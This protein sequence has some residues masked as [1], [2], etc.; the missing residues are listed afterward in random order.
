M[1]R[2]RS[3]IVDKPGAEPA[4][5]TD[6]A[7]LWTKP[8]A[9]ITRGRLH[10]LLSQHRGGLRRAGADHPFSRRGPAG[11]HGAVVR[12]G[13]AAVRSVRSRPHGPHQALRQARLHHRRCRYPAALSALRARARRLRRP[14]AQR[15]ARKNPGKPAARRDQE[16]RDQPRARRARAARRQ[17]A[18]DFRQDLGHLRRRAQGRHLRGFRA[19]RCAPEAGAF[20]DHGVRRRMAQPQGLCR[21]AQAQSDRDLLSRRRRHR[22][23]EVIAASGRFSRPRRRSAAVA[24]SGRYVLGHVRASV[25]TANRSSR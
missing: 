9:D 24:R 2:C 22:A 21:G 1:C 5:I 7:A 3:R 13:L 16:G 4:E 23:A 18:A 19:P 11:L 25:S 6:G 17:G 20:Q 8:K 10:R 12:S 15:L 14:A